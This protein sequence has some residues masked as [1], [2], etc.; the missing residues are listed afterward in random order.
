[1][2]KP[3]FFLYGP[4]GCGKTLVAEAFFGEAGI[5]R[6]IISPGDILENPSANL[7]KTAKFIER[8]H[9]NGLLIENVDSLIRDLRANPA[10]RRMLLDLIQQS[11]IE[12]LIFATARWPESLQPEELEV[13][14]HIYPVLYPHELARE[15]ILARCLQNAALDPDVDL[16][17]VAQSTEW[18]SGAELRQLADYSAVDARGVLTAEAVSHSVRVIGNHISVDQRKKRIQ[19]LLRFTAEY[20][21]SH[22]V[23]KEILD[24]FSNEIEMTGSVTNVPSITINIKE[25]IMRDQYNVGEAGAVGPGAKNF[26]QIW[27]QA[28]TTIDLAQLAQQL[29][30]LRDALQKESSKPEHSAAIHAV[31]AAEKEA[32]NGDGAKVLN[33]LSKVGKWVLEAATKLGTD[34]A[35]AAIEK[36]LGLQ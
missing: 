26:Q 11:P 14:N 34:V 13:F 9:I 8:R 25:L 30:T 1:M 21:T 32:K 31:A 20:S 33:H 22:S 36:S 6:L 7:K 24:R 15:A 10:S 27:N 28:G 5:A 12:R 2:L 23:R 4:E 19:T 18:W 16:Q 35:A 17:N 3:V 29:S